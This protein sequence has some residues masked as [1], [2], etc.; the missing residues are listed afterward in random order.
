MQILRSLKL[1]FQ[2]V[3]FFFCILLVSAWG[4]R[5]PFCSHATLSLIAQLEG[6]YSK[7]YRCPGGYLTIGFGHMV[8]SEDPIS[9]DT[10]LTKEDAFGMLYKE[11]VNC[12]DIRIHLNAPQLLSR[13]QLDALLSLSLNVGRDTLAYSTLV[14]LVNEGKFHEA[15]DQFLVWRKIE[16]KI[17]PGLVKR[18][19]AE[20]MVFMNRPLDPKSNLLPSE[21][22]GLPLKNIDEN[23]K[24][25]KRIEK[26]Y[27][28]DL[29]AEAVE[30]YTNYSDVY[31][32]RSIQRQ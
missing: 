6:F 4:D 9:H 32:S 26:Q 22:W 30:I 5:D 31:S 27:G 10:E 8:R 18:R 23:W 14:K 16:D 29:L 7:V 28:C 2:G 20:A 19:L 11:I 21:Q 24:F 1:F 17:F 25:L 13:N 15:C 3:S 12:C